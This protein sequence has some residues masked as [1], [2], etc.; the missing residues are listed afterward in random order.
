[1]RQICMREIEGPFEVLL[2]SFEVFFLFLIL[3][4]LLLYGISSFML[5]C[6]IVYMFIKKLLCFL[7]D[8]CKAVGFWEQ[9][10]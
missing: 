2:K 9:S 5:C 3:S 1:M 4:N 7:F 10:A 8:I 6:A